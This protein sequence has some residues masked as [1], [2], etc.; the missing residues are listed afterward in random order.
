VPDLVGI[1]TSVPI[2]VVY[3]AGLAPVDLNNHFIASG[4]TEEMLRVAE[5]AGFPRSSC[6][7][8]KGVYAAA[9]DLELD[10]VI[11]VAEGD[12][13]NTHAML[14]LLSADGVDVTR[15]GYPYGRD[16]HELRRRI[17]R[18]A[19]GFGVTYAAAEAERPRLESIR[20]RLREVDRLTVDGRVTGG[21]NLE[22][23]ISGS[24]MRSNPERFGADI[25]AFLAEARERPATSG[26]RVA[27]CGIPPAY[28]DLA[29]VLES[30]GVCVVLNEFPRQFAL[31][32]GGADLVE[33][34]LNFTYPYDVFFRLQALQREIAARRVDGLVHY[35]QSFCFRA[36][37]DRLLRDAVSAPVLTLEG[38]R[39]GKLDGSALTRVETFVDILQRGGRS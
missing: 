19:D 12:C 27:L 38:D 11:G 4:R 36:I 31:L 3:A 24:D 15:F 16:A 26:P 30:L 7:W 6:A 32:D 17:E 8:S 13:S 35:V 28:A 33:T 29:A 39:P 22:W 1:T 25:D 23:T 5:A 18:L 34:Y 14:E 20:D 9:K 37:Q 21:E 2:E 10:R